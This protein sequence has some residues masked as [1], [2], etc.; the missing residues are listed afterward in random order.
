MLIGDSQSTRPESWPQLALRTLGYEVHFAGAGGTGY[1][2]ANPSIGAL[3]Y[4]DSF[5]ANVW[6]LPHG[7]PSLVVVAGGGNDSATGAS[8]AAI[9]ANAEAL[10]AGLEREYPSSRFLMIGTLSR[11]TED[12]GGRR[13]EVDAL[14]CGLAAKKGIPF[15]SPGDWLTVHGL[16]D[17]LADDV[18][19]NAEGDRRAAGILL[20]E[21]QALDL[22]VVTAVRPERSHREQ[23]RVD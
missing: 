8:D 20:G 6:A 5:A 4:L 11:S 16:E 17:D 14:L 12:G 13:H 3:N 2:A 23:Q 7:D 10:L 15:V 21:L 9:L 22:D 18:H 19:L 1:V